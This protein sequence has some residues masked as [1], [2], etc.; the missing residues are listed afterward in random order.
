[1][2]E[3][4]VALII[5]SYQYE[6][7]DLRQLVAP[8]QDAE[9]LARVLADPAIGDFEVQT[10]LNE[11]SYEVNQAIEAFFA[12]RKR[13]DLLLLYFS[14]H[15]IK[16]EEGRLYFATTDT[17]RK[18]LRATAIPATLVNDVM[19]YSRSRRQVLLLDC[20]YSGAFARGMVAKAGEDIGT[21]ER[22]EGRG[23][24]V[25]TASDAMQYAFEG[26]EVKGKGVSS[27][28]TRALVRGLE[29]GEA[30]LNEDGRIS[31]DELYD[32]VYDRITDETPQQRPGKW[33]FDVQ[34]EIIIAQSP[35]TEGAELPSEPQPVLESP[36][37]R[38]R[39]SMAR[40]LDGLRLGNK[41]VS[42]RAALL[43]VLVL[44]MFLAVLRWAVNTI[45]SHPEPPMLRPTCQSSATPV[46]VGVA[47]LPNCS[48][49]FQTR[50]VDSWISEA[51][52]ISLDQ[53]F[54]TSTEARAQSGFD[55][56][57][58]GSCD[59]QGNEAV[60]LSYELTTT[61]KPDEVYEPPSLSATGSLTDVVS[62]GLALISYQHGDYDEAADQ[63][64]KLPATP[65]SPEQSLLCANS[66]LFYGRYDEA[67]DAYKEIG[68]ALN[69]GAAYNNLGVARFN[70]DLLQSETGFPQTGLFE[71]EQAIELA[72]AQGKA[73]LEL[74]AHVNRS[75]LLRR[76]GRWNDAQA[77]C[78]AALGLS[79][80]SALPYV[81]RV[82]NNLSRFA[83]S[84]GIPFDD[85]KRDLD[86]AE[87]SD[88]VPV[89]LYYLRATWHREKN[90]REEAIAAYERFFDLMR[91]RAC[92]QVDVKYVQDASYFL[93][94]LGR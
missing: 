76:A 93:N 3:K 8:A 75:D 18:L 50:L 11:P 36:F 27:V 58:W 53:A 40:L 83:G 68:L 43:T 57:V 31:L 90:Q 74:L 52:A 51:E 20:C 60:I 73:E 72:N 63:F 70:K 86:Q 61:R 22:F 71:F 37:A 14:G 84:E 46:Q 85:I 94:K 13:D 24:V 78:E 6:D 69:P 33:A 54:Q 88:D 15:G 29:T 91:N 2:A 17:R 35:V 9:A 30:D 77:D 16:D 44:V 49:D 45:L 81:C 5:A 39:E 55:I 89:K 42:R 56:V 19:R 21:R 87:R 26:D 82:L 48:K 28:F 64:N 59:E 47:Q 66:L 92:L 65:T 1:M 62:V 41:R 34:G 67:I 7:A 79:A 38:A 23:R 32:Y 25:L 10:L 4:R 12:D 80:Q